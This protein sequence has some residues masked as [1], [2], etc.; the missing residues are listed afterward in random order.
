MKASEVAASSLGLPSPWL[1][2][3][4]EQLVVSR[5]GNTLRI[6]SKAVVA[7]RIKL[8]KMVAGLQAAAAGAGVT[9][10]VIANKVKAVRAARAQRA[11]RR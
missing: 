3:M 10:R 5:E 11:V 1:A 8:R 7:A 9:S 4:G 2:G 6:E